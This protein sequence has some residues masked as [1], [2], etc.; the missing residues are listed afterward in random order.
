VVPLP[1]CGPPLL[2]CLLAWTL[3][4]APG[5]F[6]LSLSWVLSLDEVWQG[7][8]IFTKYINQVTRVNQQHRHWYLQCIGGGFSSFCEQTIHGSHYA[9]PP[10]GLCLED[11]MFVRPS[12][13]RGPYVSQGG[14]LLCFVISVVGRPWKF[15][16]GPYQVYLICLRI[17][18][19]WVGQF[20]KQFLL[21][22]YSHLEN[23]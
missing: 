5:S 14:I 2:G 8:I 17:N 3:V 11:L 23:H 9:P 1:P 19:C 4:L 7:F 13:Q 10:Q 15:L 6:S 12:K 18:P 16:Y 21:D 20:F 22:K